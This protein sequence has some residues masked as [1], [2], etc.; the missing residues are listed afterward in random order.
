MCILMRGH[1][2]LILDLYLDLTYMRH[3]ARILLNLLLCLMS[4]SR[5]L[6]IITSYSKSTTAADST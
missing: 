6:R 1:K 3:N 4:I 5:T 2:Y